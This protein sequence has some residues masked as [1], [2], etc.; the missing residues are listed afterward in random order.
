MTQYYIV[1]ADVIRSRSYD[2][3]DLMSEFMRIVEECAYSDEVG[4]L[5][6]RKSATY[7]GEFGHPLRVRRW[8][9][10]NV[11][12]VFDRVNVRQ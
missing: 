6:R 4:H 8:A 11:S 1:M 3:S 9:Q 7:S 10:V 2:G 12:H 5:I